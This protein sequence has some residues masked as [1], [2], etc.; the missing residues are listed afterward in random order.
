[1]PGLLISGRVWST[2]FKQLSIVLRLRPAL[3]LLLGATSSGTFLY[4]FVI[5]TN[6]NKLNLC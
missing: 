3:V 5:L 6:Q 2:I 4:Q 1:M